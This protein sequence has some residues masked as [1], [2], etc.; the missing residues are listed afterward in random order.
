MVVGS[1]WF[2]VLKPNT[3][4]ALSA[5]LTLVFW[6]S[7][8][9]VYDLLIKFNPLG[10]SIGFVK[11]LVVYVT[12]YAALLL[13]IIKTKRFPRNTIFFLN[14]CTAALILYNLLP[15]VVY[16]IKTGNV[17]GP[18]ADNFLFTND[19]DQRDIYYI[20]LDAYARQDVLENIIGYDN[21]KL[22]TSLKNRGFY[23]PECA[24]SNYDITEATIGSVLNIDYLQS[25]GVS[26][27]DIGEDSANNAKLIWNNKVWEYF[28]QKGYYFVTTKGY[29]SFNDITNSD[30]YLNYSLDQGKNDDISQQRFINLY[31]NTTIFRVAT[32]IMINNPEKVT[33][34]P[35]W[36]TYSFN[37]NTELNYLS[38]W[39]NQNNF[40]FSSLKK[41]P[42]LQGNF[43]VYAHINSPHPPY[44]FRS[45]GSLNYPAET[46]DEKI[47]YANTLTYLNKKILEVV[48]QL[49]KKSDQQPIIIIQADHGI[50]SL[51]SGIDKHKILSAYYL[52]GELITPP[53]ETIT[54]VNNFRLVINN[55]FDPNVEILPDMIY[56]K[57]LNE[58]QFI[59]A[60]CTITP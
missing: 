40:V 25:L 56:V 43:L 11:L 45:D 52:P 39:Y 37:E 3:K 48:D 30:L 22:L 33:H 53:Y 29:S 12:I 23:V 16:G 59:P 20:V 10:I 32:E 31:L 28:K 54:P 51:T 55:Y 46:T 41:I 18:S 8:G 5:V 19:N 15:I 34:L 14:L 50:H 58:Y 2:I 26:E 17:Q 42:E 1:F 38:S 7:F 24:L 27:S 44:V 9:H 4:A 35:Y 57:F 60:S 21:S 6:F 49:I 47:S 36:L 13:L